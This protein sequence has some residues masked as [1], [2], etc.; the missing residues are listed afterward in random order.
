MDF[1]KQ[2]Y[3]LI[4]NKWQRLA[5]REKILVSLCIAVIFIFIFTQ[6]YYLFFSFDYVAKK[7][8]LK[9]KQFM[10]AKIIPAVKKIEKI[11]HEEFEHKPIPNEHFIDFVK[12]D[13]NS[14]DEGK[15]NNDV[16]M[17]H[18]NLVRID[19]KEI[20]FDTIISWLQN[21]SQT[22]GVKVKR[23]FIERIEKKPGD[24]RFV[25]ELEE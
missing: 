6:I 17:I 4:Q 21:L 2:N 25:V 10:L 22:Y 9:N 14:L 12:Q 7:D 23:A 3:K 19:I 1:L 18:G 5:I 16:Y 20:N 24:V 15:L 8:E 11:K 13:I